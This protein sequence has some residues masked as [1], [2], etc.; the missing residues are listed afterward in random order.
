MPQSQ[1]K[2][3]IQLLPDRLKPPA[4]GGLKSHLVLTFYDV[5]LRNARPSAPDQ[6]AT[7]QV[8]SCNEWIRREQSPGRRGNSFP[9]DHKCV[10]EYLRSSQAPGHV[11]Q[12][13]LLSHLYSVTQHALHWTMPPLW[14]CCYSNVPV[15]LIMRPNLIF[16]H[17]LKTV[18]TAVS[19]KNWICKGIWL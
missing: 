7:F 2:S 1:T 13:V 16:G 3:K 14:C 5:T 19:P 8:W 12:Q 18:W 9:H 17:L 6:R 15:G 10:R 11:L 4:G